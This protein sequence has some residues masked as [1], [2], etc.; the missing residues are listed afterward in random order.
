[1]LLREALLNDG[2]LLAEA[3][4]EVALGDKV[5]D[6]ET[7]RFSHELSLRFCLCFGHARFLQTAGEL[8]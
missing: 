8:Q 5:L 7:E 3:C 4:I 2:A 1:M 6:V